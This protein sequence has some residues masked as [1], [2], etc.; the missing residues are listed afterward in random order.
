MIFL[1]FFAAILFFF[2]VGL[3]GLY[4]VRSTEEQLM[5]ACNVLFWNQVIQTNHFFLSAL[6]P[7]IS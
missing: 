5:P 2:L 6:R 4:C 1:P 7:L 3:V